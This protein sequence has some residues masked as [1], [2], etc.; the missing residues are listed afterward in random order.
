MEI[1]VPDKSKSLNP[2]LS[3][4]RSFVISGSYKTWDKDI[5]SNTSRFNDDYDTK[6]NS[7]NRIFTRN[8][9]G[10]STHA[11]DPTRHKNGIA[12]DIMKRLMKIPKRIFTIDTSRLGNSYSSLYCVMVFF[13][14]TLFSFPLTIVPQQNIIEFPW[15]WP[16]SM[17]IIP[18]MSVLLA[19]NNVFDAFLVMNTKE[20]FSFK[21]FVCLFTY[22]CSLRLVLHVIINIVWIYGLN[23]RPPCPYNSY[24]THFLG[25]AA[26]IIGFW[27][28]HP[29]SMRH[30]PVFRKR[31]KWY[32]YMR[33]VRICT[34]MTYGFV[35]TLFVKIPTRFQ[36]ILSFFI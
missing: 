14:V 8:R 29:L 27:F 33:G 34:N 1:P 20:V 6:Y 18:V 10:F 35:A 17:L 24:I 36:F 21:L 5:P 7:K 3:D 15:Y 4:S 11:S 30:D 22:N 2:Y 26:L 25:V 32:L 9:I 12:V 31:L 28:H 16:E 13:I 19:I 23:Y